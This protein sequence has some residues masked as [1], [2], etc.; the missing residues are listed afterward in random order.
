MFAVFRV[1]NHD[2]TPKNHIFSN[3]LGGGGRRVR[4]LDPPPG[5]APVIAKYFKQLDWTQI[6]KITIV[7]TSAIVNY[8]M[9]RK[10]QHNKKQTKSMQLY[11][12]SI[13][14]HTCM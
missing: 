2:F 6:I 10:T 11:N 3:F 7:H 14:N 12:I 8:K 5:S 4:P 13:F 9:E 1:K